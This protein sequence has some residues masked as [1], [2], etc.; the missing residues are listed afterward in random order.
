MYNN[1]YLSWD[2]VQGENLVVLRLYKYVERYTLV[3][4]HETHS[5]TL[6]TALTHTHTMCS[7]VTKNLD[8][9]NLVPP[10]P[11]TSKRLDPRSKYFKAVG[12]PGPNTSV[13][14]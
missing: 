12:P 2:D 3:P 11:N 5:D 9:P 10:S 14:P 13:D 1:D 7:P 4:T 6:Y 8:P